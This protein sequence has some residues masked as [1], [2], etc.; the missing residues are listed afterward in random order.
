MMIKL[1]ILAVISLKVDTLMIPWGSDVGELG[2]KIQSRQDAGPDYGPPAFD[3][4]DGR[5]VFLDRFN[6]RVA[7]FD[8]DGKFIE[9]YKVNGVYNNICLW[10]GEVILSADYSDSV[11][12]TIL[13]KFQHKEYT[14]KVGKPLIRNSVNYLKDYRTGTLF[15]TYK[16]LED[17]T[18]ASYYM[19]FEGMPG[20]FRKGDVEKSTEEYALVGYDSKGNE[21][22]V[23]FDGKSFVFRRGK[24]VYKWYPIFFA[25]IDG[26]PYRID[27]DG[28]LYIVNYKREGVEILEVRW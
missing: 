10:N 1:L 26:S 6:K 28:T 15:V 14:V 3:V 13:K 24:E 17:A 23:K 18:I 19:I 12:F 25:L 2:I 9:L 5:L 21:V 22:L 8:T 4:E 16:T 7:F 27:R 20:D 11:K